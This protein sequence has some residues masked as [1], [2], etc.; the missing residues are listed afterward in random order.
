MCVCV[1]SID[2]GR[3]KRILQIMDDYWCASLWI[4]QIVS[5]Q[6]WPMSCRTLLQSYPE[7]FRDLTP[8]SSRNAWT[9]E[10]SGTVGCNQNGDLWLVRRM[11]CLWYWTPRC[12]NLLAQLATLH[13]GRVWD[14]RRCEAAASLIYHWELPSTSRIPPLMSSLIIRNEQAGR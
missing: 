5:Q 11:C 1:K 12:W 9:I 3:C 4:F 7:N 6:K 2:Q 8:Q 10:I 14:F 13:N